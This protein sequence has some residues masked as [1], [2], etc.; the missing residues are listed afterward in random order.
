MKF[1]LMTSHLLVVLSTVTALTSEELGKFTDAVTVTNGAN[2]ITLKSDNIPEHDYGSFENKGNPNA[3]ETQNFDITIPSNPTPAAE[4]SCLP[5]GPIG[6]M[7]NGV[8]FFNPYTIEKT[9]AVENEIFDKCN[10]HPDQQGFYHYHQNP[11]CLLSSEHGEFLGVALDGYPLY[12]AIDADG[13][14]LTSDDLDECHGREVDGS[15]RYYVTEDF[16]YILGCFH[17]EL[18]EEVRSSTCYFA[19]T[20]IDGGANHIV[21]SYL[22]VFIFALV[23]VL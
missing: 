12:E 9:D 4:P 5:M 10:G 14:R 15:Y 3:V 6:M 20:D 22:S 19:N 17:G 21:I 7:V 8:G 11:T 18:A 13:V 16:P 23:T 2:T 1:L